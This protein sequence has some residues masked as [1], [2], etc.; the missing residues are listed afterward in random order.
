MYFRFPETEVFDRNNVTLYAWDDEDGNS[1][2]LVKKGG[3]KLADEGNSSE[4]TWPVDAIYDASSAS[5]SSDN[6]TMYNTYTGKNIDANNYD[7]HY[8]VNYNDVVY[9]GGHKIS[10][11]TVGLPN[12]D[13]RLI[14][15]RLSY[16]NPYGFT[17]QLDP[18]IV[19]DDQFYDVALDKDGNLGIG[20]MYVMIGDALYDN[21]TWKYTTPTAD[22]NNNEFDVTNT[23]WKMQTLDEYKS[24]GAAR[25]PV[26]MNFSPDESRSLSTESHNVEVATYTGQFIQGKTFRFGTPFDLRKSFV[27]DETVK[28]SAKASAEEIA[29]G[30]YNTPYKIYLKDVDSTY[31]QKYIGK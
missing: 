26:F 20:G 16:H 31:M 19:D 29:A 11:Y 9:Y 3:D 14:K 5:A 12:F 4:W 10:R 15:F 18:K 2:P 28:D 22:N 13:L 21:N 6:K 27:K 30:I 8:G 23:F 17:Q 7:V 24:Q 25:G 1:Y